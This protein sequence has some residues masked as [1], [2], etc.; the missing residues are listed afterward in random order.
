MFKVTEWLDPDIFTN[1]FKTRNKMNY[2]WYIFSVPFAFRGNGTET[3]SFLS[4]KVW[5]IPLEIKAKKSLEALK[6][7]IKN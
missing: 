6:G 2:N 4:L 7:A 1:T 5:G 3:I